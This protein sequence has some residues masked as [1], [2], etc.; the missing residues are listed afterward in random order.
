MDVPAPV[1]NPVKLG[2]ADGGTLV[3][4]ICTGGLSSAMLSSDGFGDCVAD[5]AADPDSSCTQSTYF[6]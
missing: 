6:N 2:A 5:L 1:D 3:M 4:G